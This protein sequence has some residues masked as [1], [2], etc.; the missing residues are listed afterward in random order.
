MYDVLHYFGN[1]LTSGGPGFENED[2]LGRIENMDDV[3]HRDEP[4]VFAGTPTIRVRDRDLLVDGA[5]GTELVEVFRTLVPEHREL[6]LATEAEVRRRIP[7]DLPKLLQLDE[8]HQPDLFE[9]PPSG[10][11]V[12]RQLAAVMATADPGEYQPTEPPNTH[13]R[14]WPESGSL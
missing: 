13:W 5:L 4:E 8:W 14:N 11:E 6:L 10:A 3:E 2:F 12:Y 1:C 7:A 9:T